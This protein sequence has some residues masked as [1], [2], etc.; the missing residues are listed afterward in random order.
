MRICSEGLSIIKEFE[1]W[2]RRPYRDPIGIP[3]IG[4]GSIWGLDRKRLTMAH[5]EITQ[6]EGEIML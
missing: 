5:R 6:D 2:S 1:G 4:Y 3:T